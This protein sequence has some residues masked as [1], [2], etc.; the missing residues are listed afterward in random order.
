MIDIRRE[1]H[2]DGN[3]QPTQEADDSDREGPIRDRYWTRPLVR[4]VGIRRLHRQALQ[5]A[6]A[7][8][9]VF[10]LLLFTSYRGESTVPDTQ[11]SAEHQR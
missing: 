7:Q 9:W 1:Q 10:D 4:R 5:L 3:P 2:N 8:G 6:H 11:L